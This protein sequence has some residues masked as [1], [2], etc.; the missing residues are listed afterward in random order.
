MRKLTD[1]SALAC[2]RHMLLPCHPF[3]LSNLESKL[4][5]LLVD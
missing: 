1:R 4:Y 3:E 5:K 2:V